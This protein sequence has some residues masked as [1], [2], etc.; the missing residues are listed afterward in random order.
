MTDAQHAWDEQLA[1]VVEASRT[2]PKAWLP[3]G[4]YDTLKWCTLIALPATATLYSAL[5]A[6][7]SW[8]FS[9]EVAMSVTAICTFLGVLLGLSKA[10]YKAKDIDV[11]GTV[12]LGGA[13][14][15]LSLDAPASPGDKVTLKV[16]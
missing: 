14:A 1:A 7:W 6:V 12:R 8:G 2:Q 9:G 15:Q 5:A 13:D 16:L 3:A 4:L 10:D 11:N